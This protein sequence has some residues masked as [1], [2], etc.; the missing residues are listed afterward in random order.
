[1]LGSEAVVTRRRSRIRVARDRKRWLT[2][3]IGRSSFVLSSPSTQE[4]SCG[5]DVAVSDYDNNMSD[6]V[7]FTYFV[8]K[9][10]DGGIRGRHVASCVGVDKGR[11]G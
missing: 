5:F 10:L 2:V 6:N 8:G 4:R 11:N 1:M 7:S 3:T 9:L